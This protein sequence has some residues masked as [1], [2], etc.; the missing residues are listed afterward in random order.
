MSVS[1]KLGNT[2]DLP[3]SLTNA[4]VIF[5]STILALD[6]PT[7]EDNT[8]IYLLNSANDVV[9]VLSFRR[10][11]DAVVLNTR[12]AGGSWQG[13]VIIKGLQKMFGTSLSAACIVVKDLGSSFQ[14][15]TNGNELAVF[16][17]RISGEAVK[18]QYGVN[19]G[20]HSTFSDPLSVV[21]C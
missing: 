6:Q 7:E 4:Q 13:E 9:L 3:K 15:F 11:Q 16:Q 14:I 1:L 10:F 19:S 17:K 8:S 21:I 18:A 2:V 20:T 12:P 5:F